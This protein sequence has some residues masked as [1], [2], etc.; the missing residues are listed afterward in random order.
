MA[1]YDL[2]VRGGEI[3]DGLGGAPFI[4]DVAVKDGRIAAIGTVAGSAREEVD[5]T[6]RIVTPG[7][8]D[9]HTHFDGQCT[10][11]NTLAP[12]SIH[13]VTTVVMGNCGVG[14][15][16]CK[17]E[18]RELL[19]EVM[20]GVEDIPE[21]VM[22]EGVP[23][24][25]ETFPEYLDALDARE[26][27]IDVCA[28]IPHSALRVYVMGER[29]C[30]DEP[31]TAHDLAE[32]RRLVSEAIEAGALGV[33]TSRNMI[34]RTKAGELAPSLHSL[35]RELEELA[36]GLADTGK[37]VFQ[38]IPRIDGDPR[39]EFEIIHA[40]AKA[41]Q[42]PVSFTLAAIGPLKHEWMKLPGRMDAAKAEGLT[43]RG[44]V[45]PRPI[46][47]LYG[48]DLRFHPFSLHPS[49]QEIEDLPL[50]EKV[51]KMRDPEF[52]R[53]LLSEQPEH[54]NPVS[55]QFARRG[56][57]SYRLANPPSYEPDPAQR[58][59]RL[60]AEQHRDAM[61]YAY[62]ALLEDEGRRILYCP[63]GFDH[64]GIGLTCELLHDDNTLVGLSDGGAH[65]GSICD[66]SFPTWYLLRWA[67]D[68]APD[69]RIPLP[70]AI[71]ELTSKTAD[72]VG[73]G[74]RGR[75]VIGAR[76]DLNVIDLA[77]LS[78]QAPIV[79]RD[80]PAGARRLHQLCSGYE[81]TIKNGLVT[82]RNGEP[83]GALPGR[84]V[85]GAQTVPELVAA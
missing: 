32:M 79:R 63:A 3:H 45:A 64:G 33:T 29:A 50:A 5:A 56:L 47:V 22:A 80:L 9:I 69:E 7:F 78:L 58:I 81:V 71:A 20:E 76:G 66:S 26:L 39:E 34:H 21:V 67:R 54:S 55:I 30:G 75:L 11:E 51:A 14:F 65:Y 83:T 72:A 43:I 4:G 48:L 27:D 42:R 38:M 23:W 73:L 37:G 36:R 12:S 62:D 10:W 40:V 70:R 49:F 13:G 60:A 53:Q 17:P 68:A 52:R 61:E 57:Y 85:R 18:Q 24:N 19:I 44:Q 84:L 41:G 16:P 46:G 25:W 59:D 74:D 1:D 28:Q 15:A 82:Y 6:G 35:T 77:G 31:P 2:I 8:V